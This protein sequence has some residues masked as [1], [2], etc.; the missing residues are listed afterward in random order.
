MAEKKKCANFTS[1]ALEVLVHE[2]QGKKDLL[3]GKLAV[4]LTAEEKRKA[5]EE[6][7]GKVNEVGIGEIRT[8]K[9]VRKKWSDMASATKKKEAGRRRDLNGTGG[10]ECK[11]VKLSFNE[12]KVVEVLAGESIEGVPGGIDVGL[13]NWESMDFKVLVTDDGMVEAMEGT[14]ADISTDNM[15]N[16]KKTVEKKGGRGGASSKRGE[17]DLEAVREIEGKRLKIEVER[18]GLEKERLEIERR[19]LEIEEERLILEKKKTAALTSS[20]VFADE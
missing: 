13:I 15:G 1:K 4:T 7:A 14:L 5:W 11:D 12:Q 19:C 17:M 8:E 2:V 16:I 20:L 9:A 6:V 10:G 18:L 3:F